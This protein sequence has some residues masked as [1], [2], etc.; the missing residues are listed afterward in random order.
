MR[1]LAQ[2]YGKELVVAQVSMGHTL[3]DYAVHQGL[4]SAEYEEMADKPFQGKKMEYP[5]TKQGQ[6]SHSWDVFHPATAGRWIFHCPLAPYPVTQGL[7]KGFFYWEPAWIPAPGSGEATKASLK[8]V[9][10]SVPCGNERANRA[11]FDYEGKP[12]PA[13]NVIK[14]FKA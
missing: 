6:Y 1:D 14:N 8:Y 3:E 13:L 11:L 10:D 5:V 12:L 7:G 2:R 9:K 4:K